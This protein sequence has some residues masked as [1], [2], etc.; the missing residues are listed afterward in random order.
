MGV[1]VEFPYQGRVINGQMVSEPKTK[2]EYLATCKRF[3]SVPEYEFV[4]LAIMDTDYYDMSD[5]HL[6]RIVDAYNSFAK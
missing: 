1:V 3:L 4:I 5:A 6:A 2:S